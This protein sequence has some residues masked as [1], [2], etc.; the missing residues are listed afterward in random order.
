MG[1]IR[2]SGVRYPDATR[3]QDPETR[4]FFAHLIK[5]LEDRDRFLPT[6]PINKDQ[7]TVKPVTITRY[8]DPATATLPDVINVL[9]TLLS[10]LG[11]AGIIKQKDA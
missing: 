2:T 5:E 9:A 1:A 3:V 11:S 4:Q 7:Y 6:I 8:F 10:D